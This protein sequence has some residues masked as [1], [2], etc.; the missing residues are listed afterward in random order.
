VVAVLGAAIVFVTSHNPRDVVSAD[1]V[2]ETKVDVGVTDLLV[3]GVVIGLVA[4]VVAGTLSWFATRRAVQPLGDALRMQRAFVA[5]A[6]H[7]LRTP[8]AV[9]DARLQYL[10]RR[11]DESDPVA[12]TIDELRRDTKTLITIVNDLLEAAEVGSS[13]DAT[14]PVDV[15]PVVLLAVESMRIIAE[16]RDVTIDFQDAPTVPGQAPPA[17]RIPAASIHRCVV[18]LLDNALDF[19]PAGSSIRVTVTE[20]KST[21]QISVR[22]SGPGIAGIEPHHIFDR[23]SRGDRAAGG[24][25]RQGFGIGLSLVRDTVERFG[26]RAEVASTSPNG[27]EIEL[28]IPLAT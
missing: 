3:A 17:T 13:R 4:I 23:F 11:L 28:V 9:L 12:P 10:R 25:T 1:G 24:A 19:S 16:E 5:D 6:S 22:D 14:V 2:H 21:V 27:T 8:L 26:G 15:S 18:A 7:E 20:T